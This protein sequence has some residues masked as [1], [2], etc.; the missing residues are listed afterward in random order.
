MPL[1]TPEFLANIPIFRGTTEA[2]RAQLLQVM[3][4]EHYDVGQNVAV[5][6]ESS[7]GLH[8]VIEGSAVVVLE[9]YGYS[10]PMLDETTAPLV[11]HAEIARLDIG[12]TFGEVSFLDA[13]PHTATV[14][15]ITALELLTLSVDA[16]QELIEH[17][18][19]AAFKLATNCA[20]MLAARLR[21]ADQLI[22]EL[23]LAQQDIHSRHRWFAS[24]MGMH[25]SGSGGFRFGV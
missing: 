6:G 3:E 2:E 20:K 17:E 18:N 7:R 9:V 10:N 4:R 12:T 16:F 13:G 11:E 8:V 23:L 5:A 21:R 19:Q 15:A 1:L 22:G 24:H 14:R 25:T